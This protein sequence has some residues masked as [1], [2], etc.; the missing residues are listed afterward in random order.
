MQRFRHNSRRQQTGAGRWHFLNSSPPLGP[1]FVVPYDKLPS[2][3]WH[4][5]GE[6]MALFETELSIQKATLYLAILSAVCVA[7]WAVFNRIYPAPPPLPKE[8]VDKA[9]PTLENP[10]PPAV[11]VRF[12]YGEIPDICRSKCPG[13]VFDGDVPCYQ[14]EIKLNALCSKY[15]DL[16]QQ[17]EGGIPGNMCGY[18]MIE[19]VCLKK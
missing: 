15:S 4:G 11:S 17:P 8:V 18:A 2:W 19:A 16:K 6:N 3:L 14:T 9:A 5:G 7:G 12:C 13:V 1:G 10:S